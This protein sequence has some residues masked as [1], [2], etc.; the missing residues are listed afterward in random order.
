M[1]SGV[2]ERG[3]IGALGEAGGVVDGVSGDVEGLR[4]GGIDAAIGGESIITEGDGDHR[5]A[6]DIGGEGIGQGAVGGDGRGDAEES[7]IGVSGDV[8]G[9]ELSG[10]ARSGGDGGGPA[11]NG[12]RGIVFIDGLIGALGEAGGIVNTG[13]DNVEVLRERGID[14]AVGGSPTIADGH[15]NACNAEGIRSEGV[16]QSAVGGDGGR[17]GEERWIGVTGDVEGECLSDFVGGGDGSGGEIGGPAVD[18]VEESVFEYGFIGALGEAGGIVDRIDRDGHGPDHA[19]Q[20][21]FIRDLKLKGIGS[22]GI[23]IGRIVVGPRRRIRN[24]DDT[25]GSGDTC[26][27]KGER[28]GG[29]GVDVATDQCS[30]VSGGIFTDRECAIGSRRG[31][32][33]RSRRHRDGPRDRDHAILQPVGDIHAN[34]EVFVIVGV[35]RK[36]NC[37]Q[38]RVDGRLG[39][40]HRQY[41]VG[42]RGTRRRQG[43]GVVVG[44]VQ[45]RR[46]LLIQIGVVH[47]DCAQ[48]HAAAIFGVSAGLCCIR[49]RGL[50]VQSGD[51]QPHDGVSA[52]CKIS[53]VTDFVG[54]F[55][56][57][58]IA[59]I[60]RLQTAAGCVG[61][62]TVRV[63]HGDAHGGIRDLD[64]RAGADAGR[65]IGQY[66]GSIDVED[67]VFVDSR[68]IN[69]QN[70]VHRHQRACFQAFAGLSGLRRDF[71]LLIPGSGNL[72]LAK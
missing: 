45:C 60:E 6:V 71:G 42:E 19:G 63:Q 33:H 4:G 30:V 69:V 47:H 67:I 36:G 58:E 37:G 68:T 32:G 54:E 41:P 46:D 64:R 59:M 40:G 55:L 48:R 15:G 13:D 1:R 39:S 57:G 31:I 53:G 38:R 28:G 16:G 61:E 65:V 34:C 21:C 7:G 11:S 52:D 62:R 44:K 26:Q 56:N 9:E 20:Q 17:H 18:G 27:A 2:F 8:E 23:G 29:I 5:R 72:L 70:R 49:R 35:R 10:F 14:S 66:A 24:H 51:E 3:F 25:L 12:L 43:S 50:I 22:V